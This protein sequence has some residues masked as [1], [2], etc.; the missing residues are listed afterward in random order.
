[1]CQTYKIFVGNN[2]LFNNLF[3]ER[4]KNKW[5]NILKFSFTDVAMIM[6]DNHILTFD[7]KFY[8]IPDIK[9]PGCTYL[10]AHD[11]ADDKFSLMKTKGGIIIT[12]PG[13]TAEIKGKN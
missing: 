9:K 3:Q 13:M 2:L 8:D 6:G 11:F 5:F 10:L 12:T 7:N 1:M 4:Y